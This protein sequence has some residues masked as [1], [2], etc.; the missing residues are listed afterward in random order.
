MY[1]QA[2]LICI[3]WGAVNYH[4]SGLKPLFN[5][6]KSSNIHYNIW[7]HF[8]FIWVNTLLYF[9]SFVL[10][11][12]WKQRGIGVHLKGS[13]EFPTKIW[14]LQYLIMQPFLPIIILFFFANNQVILTQ[15]Q[16]K[17]LFTN[18]HLRQLKFTI[19]WQY[20]FLNYNSYN[21]TINISLKYKK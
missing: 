20:K 4:S 2:Y 14:V 10:L 13:E 15:I 1:A 21:L 18:S 19:M 5:F 3:N 12:N 7:V 11:R 9:T 6:K 8:I 16:H 17:Q